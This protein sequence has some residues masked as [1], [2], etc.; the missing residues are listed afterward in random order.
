MIYLP[1]TLLA[2]GGMFIY[3]T[4]S[5]MCYNAW[6]VEDI[7]KCQKTSKKPLSERHQ[8]VHEYCHIQKNRKKLNSEKSE[9]NYNPFSFR[10][11]IDFVKDI[12]IDFSIDEIHH[13][14]EKLIFLSFLF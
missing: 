6:N 8:M 14:I 2:P 11:Y 13:G 5:T 3:P 1:L 4:T 9:N 12:W 7:C 10:F